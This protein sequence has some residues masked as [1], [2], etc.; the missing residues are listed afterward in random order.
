MQLLKRIVLLV[1]VTSLFTSCF[2]DID[3]DLIASSDINRFIWRGMN[4]YYLYKDNVPDLANDRFGSDVE[5]N[6]FDKT[7][8]LKKLK[9]YIF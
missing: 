1:L 4:L 7:E 5:F 3:D 9:K 2:N 6:N 8:I